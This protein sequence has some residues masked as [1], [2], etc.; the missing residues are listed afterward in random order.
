MGMEAAGH[1]PL[2]HEQERLVNGSRPREARRVGKNP[3][4]VHGVFRV[5]FA[6]HG[7]GVGKQAVARA[8]AGTQQPGGP[9]KHGGKPQFLDD[10]RRIEALQQVG[11]AEPQFILFEF[12]QRGES[13]RPCQ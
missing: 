2:V 13:F 3:A 8:V 5:D 6:D 4:R 10:L 1:G 7:A 12:R 11:R 9:S